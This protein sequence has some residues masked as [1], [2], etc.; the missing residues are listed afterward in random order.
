MFKQT[1]DELEY[2]WIIYEE[3][4]IDFDN[5]FISMPY[6][7]SIVIKFLFLHDSMKTGKGTYII[8]IIDKIKIVIL[9]KKSDFI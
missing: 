7:N 5:S 4:F 1:K 2:L 3:L 9:Q 6:I 8:F